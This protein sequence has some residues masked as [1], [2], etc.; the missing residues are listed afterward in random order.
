MRLLCHVKGHQWQTLRE[1]WI[2]PKDAEDFVSLLRF[3]EC[4]H[5][6]DIR[7]HL[8]HPL[9]YKTRFSMAKP[10]FHRAEDPAAVAV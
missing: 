3:D 4:R 6:H 8:T 5:C 1:E 10:F 9:D 2:P 7:A